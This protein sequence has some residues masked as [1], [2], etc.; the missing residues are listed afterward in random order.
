MTGQPV[1]SAPPA[2]EAAVPGP[3]ARP[4][5]VEPQPE[6]RALRILRWAE[7]AF[8][9]LVI[10]GLVV[11]FWQISPGWLN[12]QTAQLIISQNAPLEVTAVGMTFAMISANIDLSPGSMLS[13]AGMVMGLVAARSGSLWVGMAAALVLVIGVGWLTGLLVG[14]L[15]I[16]SIIVTL[17]TYIW[18]AG[19][20]LSIN[21]SYAI[22]MQGR[23]FSVLNDGIDGWTT[24]ILVVVVFAAVGQAL[25]V[26]T[27]FGR[28]SRAIG[29]N[30]EFAR[31]SGIPGPRYVVYVFC[32]MGLSIFVATVLSVAQLGA[33]Q[34]LAGSGLELEAIVAVVI[35]G[36]RL[37]GGE[38]SV[39]RSAI[40]ALLLAVLGNGLSSLG[41]SSAYYDLWE[42]V[43]L[44]V[45][46]AA[47]VLLQRAVARREAR[48]VVLPQPAQ[49]QRPGEPML[50][51]A[52]IQR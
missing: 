43:A 21:G 20:A 28:Y 47:S 2:Q 45:V 31:R 32:F 16:S 4:R 10:V 24:T 27:R 9:L 5:V 14:R 18:A 38:G 50:K 7:R 34:P 22:Q 51:V 33:A 13:L 36:T 12:S 15:R 44:L 1:P 25:L 17:A 11:A 19:L 48:Q 29:G 30:F 35:G 40:G 46:L 37:T 8:L 6:D 49:W 41:L 52:G 39:V 23:I 42:G 26:G 3:V